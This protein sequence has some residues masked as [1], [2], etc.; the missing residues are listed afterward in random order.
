MEHINLIGID[1][2][3]SKTRG[4]LK[5]GNTIIAQAQMGTTR[6]GSI[7]TGESCERVLNLIKDLCKTANMELN[8]VEGIVVGLAGIW[9]EEERKRYANLLRTLARNE[10]TPINEVLLTSD[11]EIALVGALGG[12]P[13]IIQIAGTGT[14]TLAKNSAG[15]MFR[16]SGWGIEI[17]DEGSGAWIGRECLTAIVRA[18]DG[19]DKT[20]EMTDKVAER[21]ST[22]NKN[23]PRTLVAALNEKKFEYHDFT[24]M[25]MESAENG[26]EVAYSIL[27]R[28][29]QHLTESIKT[30]H[31]KLGTKTS[32]VCLMGGMLENETILLRLLKKNLDSKSGIKIKKPIGNALDGALLLAADMVE[33]KEI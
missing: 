25:A 8:E 32:D 28:A 20:T 15:E 16:C 13:G 24:K 17:D 30:L 29:S 26:D 12:K 19:R 11:A 27:E 33:I 21:Y 9:L 22:F 2:G 4:V 18:L 23:N 10:K 6:V 14:I 3:G 31:K 5:S 1:G 7:G